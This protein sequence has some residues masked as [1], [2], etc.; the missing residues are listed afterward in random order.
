MK[1]RNVF[2]S[3]ARL[4]TGEVFGR[5]ATF[6]LFAYVSR[7]FGVE[8]LGIVAL[9][10]TV[11]GYVM[12]CSDQGLK[13]IGARLLARNHALA[14]FVVPFVLKRRAALTA[15]AIV[16]GGMYAVLGPVP[17]AARACVLVFDL[18]VVPYAFALDWVAWGLGYFGVLSIWRS[19]VSILYV[20]MAIV[21]MRLTMRP[22]ASIS[23]ANILSALAGAGF[24]WMMWR[25]RWKRRHTGVTAEQ[26]RAAAEELRPS[27]VATL[28]MSNLLNLV[29][30]NADI[31]LLGAITSTAEVGRYSAACKPLYIIF[32]GFWLLTD[33]LYPYLAKV[34]AGAQTYRILLIALAGLAVT[35][36]AAALGIGLLAPQILTLI[37]GSTLGAARLFRILLIALPIDFY[38]SLL[39]TVLVSRG[40]ERP[41]LYSLGAAAG[42]NVFLNL[43]FIPRFQANAAA[44]TTVASYAL[45]FLVLLV[46]VLKNKVLSSAPV[47]SAAE[48]R[49]VWT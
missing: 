19:G 31:L 18:A 35:A 7:Q 12:E 3:F 46:F 41:V 27:R 42:V 30:M 4:A 44:W 34:E 1:I 6:A 5:M 38:F 49:A 23:G 24:L 36:S 43:V 22:I 13:L 17:P 25:L 48:T 40:Y 2:F 39:W 15:I 26:V 47:S 11:A 32:T 28:G 45:L 10:Q 9:A 29:F 20:A 33:A 16:L 21:A 14:T 37:Y 8:I